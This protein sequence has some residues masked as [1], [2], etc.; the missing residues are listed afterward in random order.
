M[1]NYYIDLAGT[2]TSG[3]S[4]ERADAHLPS[5]DRLYLNVLKREA[6]EAVRGYS[7]AELALAEKAFEMGFLAAHF[8]N[9]PEDKRE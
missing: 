7:A 9:H 3:W 8:K 5:E 6:F 4:Y 1:K 2:T